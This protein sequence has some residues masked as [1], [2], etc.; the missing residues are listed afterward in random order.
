MKYGLR[1][2]AFLLF[3]PVAFADFKEGVEYQKIA[4]AQPTAAED[5]IEVLELFWYGCPHCYDLESE[6]D[7]WQKNKADDVV[8]VRVPAVLG[9]SWE[10]G[11][12]AYYTAELLGV[13][14][15][16][17]KPLFERFHKEKKPIRNMD[18][19]KEFFLTRGVSEKDFDSTINSFAV[20]TKT[21]RAK[22]VRNMYGISGVPALIVNGK[23]RTSAR[24]AGGDKKMFEVVDFLVEKE[25]AVAAS[26]PQAAAQ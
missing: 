14:D 2:L 26:A 13:T 16:I 17:H 6:L 19:L 23:Y 15:Q 21:N 8:F 5:K 11:A 4:R 24:L 22:Q 18:Q 9:K 20:I 10:L 7:A 3:V 12:R 25:R 1:L